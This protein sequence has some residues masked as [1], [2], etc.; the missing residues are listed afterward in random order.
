MQA[1]GKKIM[2]ISPSLTVGGVQKAALEMAMLLHD[3]G[4][5]VSLCLLLK[6]P[7]FFVL[8]TGIPLVEPGHQAGGIWNRMRQMRDT[9]LEAYKQFEPEVVVV[10]GRYYSAW[11]AWALRG[12]KVKVVVSDRNSPLFVLPL[13]QRTW[14]R[15]AYM[16]NPPSMALAQTQAAK[17]HQL[18]YYSTKWL[19]LFPFKRKPEVILFPNLLDALKPAEVVSREK[20][21]LAVGRVT[22]PLKGLDWLLQVRSLV[23]NTEWKWVLAGGTAE[24]NPL[25][26]KQVQDLNLTDKII[27]LGKVKD[28]DSWY[29]KA[30]I[31]IMTSK[32][33][34]FPNALAEAMQHGMPC[35]AYDF[36]G[37]AKDLIDNEQVGVLVEYGN[38]TACAAAIED[39]MENEEKRLALGSAAAESVQR[40]VRKN[41][42]KE[43]RTLFE[44]L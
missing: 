31:F 9:V 32:S 34:G 13:W 18:H 11:A 1:L 35:V 37:G 17:Q 15:L 30:G 12:E 43:V 5:D 33:E 38:H 3:T 7:H 19:G 25:L 42:I 10:Y 28:L 41:R 23:E 39:L 4:F 14:I 29:R 16:I 26:W 6:Q 44:Q 2:V 22:D 20:I 24:E 21:V 8:E 36:V 40:L 27:F